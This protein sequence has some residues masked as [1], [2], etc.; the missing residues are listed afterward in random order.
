MLFLFS[1][2]VDVLTV[3]AGVGEFLHT[4]LAL[5]G[6][7]SAVKS[8]VFHEVML[9]FESFVA[10][11]T[12][13]WPVFY[14]KLSSVSFSNI[15]RALSIPELSLRFLGREFFFVNILVWSM[16]SSELLVNPLEAREAPSLAKLM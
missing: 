1:P 5:V 4:F 8:L 3:G 14:Q 2:V 11:I 15:S 10:A 9:V 16:S 6:L 7:L 13:V 12:L